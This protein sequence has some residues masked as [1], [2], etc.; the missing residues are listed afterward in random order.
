MKYTKKID[1]CKAL[2]PPATKTV[3]HLSHA[4]HEHEEVN[5]EVLKWHK[6]RAT[7]FIDQSRWCHDDPKNYPSDAVWKEHT[8]HLSYS[9]LK[10][11][12]EFI[13]EIGFEE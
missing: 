9:Q 8:I 12:I 10:E 7:I 5:V 1:G 13:D 6:D 4:I 2:G 11:I 3:S